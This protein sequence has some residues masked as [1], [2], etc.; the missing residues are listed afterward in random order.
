MTTKATSA[1]RFEQLNDLVD[2]V[3]QQLPTPTHGLVL[4]VCWR[5]A[6]RNRQ[7]RISH[8]RIAESIKVSRRSAIRIMKSLESV[9]VI[10]LIA[11]GGGT[12]A[13]TYEITGKVVTPASP[14]NKHKPP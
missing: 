6:N 11:K 13:S 9:G 3:I 1:K 10:K 5:H 8:G 12:Q 2:N 4:V 7:F 14:P